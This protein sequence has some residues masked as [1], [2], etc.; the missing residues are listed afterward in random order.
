MP[1]TENESLQ[2]LLQALARNIDP[3]EAKAWMKAITLRYRE[4][5]SFYHCAMMEIET[6]FKVLSEDLSFREDRN[7][8]ESIRTR[9]KSPESILGKLERNNLPLTIDSIEN[10]ISDIAGVRVICTFESDIYRLVEALLKQDD[11]TLIQEKDYIQEPKES[12]YRSLHLIVSVPIF[13]HDEKKS[14]RVEVQFRTLAMDLWAS[15]EHIIRYKQDYDFGA[16]DT[17]A[18]K[19]CSDLCALLDQQLETIYKHRLPD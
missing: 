4:I 3:E 5:M 8:I 10:Q 14:M 12:G 6:K 15:T 7:P 9:L 2:P 16:A 11:I 1:T 17:S 13:L 18:L 19:A